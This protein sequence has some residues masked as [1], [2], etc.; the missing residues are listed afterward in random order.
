MIQ[1]QPEDRSVTGT[2]PSKVLLSGTSYPSSPGG[3]EG[4]F[5]RHMVDALARR[6]DLRLSAWLPPGELAPGV[7]DTTTNSDARWLRELLAAGGIAHLLRRKPIRGSFSALGLLRRLR[8][9]YVRSDADL[10]HV[11]WLQNALALPADTRPALVTALGTDMRLLELPGMQ[12][13]LRRA[14]RK[15]RVVLCPNADWMLR[16]L[17][18]AFGDVADVR[19]TAFGIDPRWYAVRRHPP[20]D[21]P[22][23]WLCV[24]RLTAAKLGPLFEWG[25]VHF[26]GSVRELHLFGPAQ[27]DV[28]VPEWVQW[29]GPATPEH[30]CSEWFPHACGLISLS[31]HAEGRPQVMLEAMA[32]GLPVLASRIPAHED[33]VMHDLTGWVCD[34]PAGLAAGIATMEDPIR[35]I[36]IGQRA[37]DWVRNNIGDWDDCASRY[38]TQYQRL[39][40]ARP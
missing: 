22:H 1:A 30:L 7:H 34:D 14:F 4:Q 2:L 8:A 27:E 5:I 15:R 17:E 10:F 9:A 12:S 33:I 21:G 39:L 11:N 31:R 28:A 19:V 16:P 29:H 13:L 26:E 38:A 18:R 23:R 6:D 35:N 20:V 3:W 25:R 37:H 40:A 24:T 36:D 32:S